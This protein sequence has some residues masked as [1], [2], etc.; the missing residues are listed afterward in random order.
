[1]SSTFIIAK[2]KFDDA[3]EAKIAAYNGHYET[4]ALNQANDVAEAMEKAKDIINAQAMLDD[5]RVVIYKKTGSSFSKVNHEKLFTVYLD[6]ST[7]DVEYCKH[8]VNNYQASSVL[9]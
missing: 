7:G 1:M 5:R 3:F 9:H 2:E 6:R 4:L 8:L